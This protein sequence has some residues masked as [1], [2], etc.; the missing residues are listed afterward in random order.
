MATPA[1]SESHP[2]SIPSSSSATSKKRRLSPTPEIPPLSPAFL[3]AASQLTVGFPATHAS[4]L[5]GVIP[6]ISQV[7]AS[8]KKILQ[9]SPPIVH[10][11]KSD[12]APQLK[13][14]QHLSVKGGM[15]GYRTSRASHGVNSG[16]YYFEVW[17]P[18]R[19]STV[20]EVQMILPPNVRLAPKLK[21]LLQNSPGD[22]I[23]G[24]TRI[25]WSMRL[26]DL[27][28]PVGYDKWS[29]GFRDIQG[30]R[31]HNSRRDDDWGSIPYGPGDVVGCAI[32]MDEKQIFFFRNGE[33]MGNFVVTRGKREGG[34]A[35]ENIAEGTYYPAISVYMGASARANFGPHFV[36]NPRKLPH[37]VKVKPL[38]DLCEKPPSEEEIADRLSKL[39][40]KTDEAWIKALEEAMTAESEIRN[41]VYQ[42]YFKQHLQDVRRE[43]EDRN[44]S[45]N[46][47]DN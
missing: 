22:T 21:K 38:C 11:S 41:E 29:Y 40:K 17:I 33:A 20:D 47:L 24:H 34:A 31:V 3:H 32:S 8:S 10:L 30:S 42:T 43:R 37:G 15:K 36:Y 4:L 12:T 27:Q 28:A 5:S 6:S 19:A 26:G 18:R 46:D 2:N 1:V 9:E 23:V 45:T 25:G 7:Q 14:D 44:L 13:I 35:F 16:D 39:P